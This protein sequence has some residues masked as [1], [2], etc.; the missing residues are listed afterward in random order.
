MAAGL[1]YWIATRAYA[2]ADAPPS[3]A[4]RVQALV[5]TRLG[6]LDIELTVLQR[7]KTASEARA[8]FRTARRNY[9]SVEGLLAFYAPELVTALNSDESQPLDDDQ[10]AG[11][12]T[13]RGFQLIEPN[14]FP[15]FGPGALRRD[16]TEIAAMRLAL[17]RFRPTIA[18]IA[19]SD[20]DLFDIARFE[21]ARVT[22]LGIAGFD[23]ADSHDGIAESADAVDGVRTL[24][25]N[26]AKAPGV[27]RAL[28]FAAAYLRAHADFD[29][30]DR[31]TFI[32]AYANPAFDSLARWRPAQP[33]G[34]RRTWPDS[35]ASV[36]D[37]RR[38]DVLSF[39]PPNAHTTDSSTVALGRDLFFDPRLSG[40]G[41]RACASCHVPEHG[42]ADGLRVPA[43]INPAGPRPT[44]N[45]PS[46]LNAA[47]QPAQFADERRA[48]LEDQIGDVLASPAEMG[49]SV[50]IAAE[51]AHIT[52]QRLR[53]AVAMYIRSLV[54]LNSP[55]DRAL[56][57]DPA[58]I[59]DDARR[60]FN[61]FMGKAACGTCHFAPTFSGTLPPAFTTSDAEV[62][63]VP[64][65]ACDKI[66]PDLGRGTID[67][68]L[69]MAHAFKTPS[70]RNAA[71][72]APYMHNGALRTLDDVIEFYDR[73][74][75]AGAG[76]SLPNQTLSPK[77]LHLTAA[78]RRA[79]V[80]FLESLTDT[81]GLT[82]RPQHPSLHTSPH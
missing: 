26:S 35:V 60:G 79:L 29:S 27:E 2:H 58:Q 32:R 80:A 68:R 66:D 81:A 9:K 38:F 30:F 71:I 61:L 69:G 56:R 11:F 77:P 19:P 18:Y 62:I 36:Y 65:L 48:T 28:G 34:L 57:G 5:H 21:L 8:A 64:A 54:A 78:E 23:A 55:F 43:P 12:K 1:A 76:I 33:A 4:S 17:S 7:A 82:A 24:V 39:A 10:A 37:A 63:G 25:H 50:E 75:G 44:R 6:S 15:E 31:F 42:F 3:R 51:R 20:A 47:L 74:G 22:T 67:R 72:T 70:V 40:N 45:T 52:P 46:L 14:L 16:S 73:G 53:T 41:Q 49:S 13:P 59:T